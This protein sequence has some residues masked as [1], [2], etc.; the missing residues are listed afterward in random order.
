MYSEKSNKT[1]IPARIG[2]KNKSR[3]VEAGFC[4]HGSFFQPKLTVG[5][6]NDPAERQADQLADRVMRQ[7]EEEQEETLQAKISPL[8]VQRFCPEC[9]EEEEETLQLKDHGREPTS[10]EA[11]PIVNRALGSSGMP[12]DPGTRA[13]M[14]NRM[15]YDFSNVKIH[16]GSLASRSAQ[17]IQ[18]LA[19]TSGNNIVFNDGQY[20]PGTPAGN[21]LLAHELTHVVQQGHDSIRAIQRRIELR[22]PGRGEATAFDRAQELVDKIN[23]QSLGVMYFLEADGRN[24]AYR[25]LIPDAVS[26]FDFQMMDFINQDQVLPLRL[27]TSQGTVGGFPIVGDS[28]LH[29]YVDLEDLLASDDLAFQSI[30][31]HFLQERAV[32]PRYEQR[33]GTPGLDPNTPAGAVSFRRAHRAGHDAQADHWQDVMGDS[34]IRF[35]TEFRNANGDAHIVFRSRDHNYRI[36]ITLRRA[37][38]STTGGAPRRTT[39]GITRIRHN[40]QWFSVEDFL[41]LGIVPGA[42]N[43][44]R[45]RPLASGFNR[46]LNLGLGLPELQL[47]PEIQRQIRELRSLRDAVNPAGPLQLPLPS[48]SP[49]LPSPSATQGT[50]NPL[51]N[52]SLV[53]SLRP[54][55]SQIDWL[56]IQNELHTRGVTMDDQLADSITSVWQ[57]NYRFFNQT[58]GMSSD[59]AT[60]WTNKTIGRAVG[61]GL[62]YDFPTMLEQSDRELGTSS[63]IFP[64]SDVLM[65][66]WDRL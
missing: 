45:L 36:F 2:N 63:T 18:A 48:P 53:P 66:L 58:L 51:L 6:A 29:G 27:I 15:G 28:Y 3:E 32:T 57:T 22:P 40:N 61:S 43:R 59:Q 20:A 7:E 41:D 62:S 9:E 12:L 11:P 26:G 55:N 33:I 25:I 34:S 31:V 17:S 14:E 8:S 19:Y 65:F 56:P 46:D 47:D 60:F 37:L 50:P 42:R 23:G 49:G 13:N 1:G 35:S 24:L 64:V 21:K 10:R 39:G 38:P 30:L 54:G 16:T 4:S 52:P 44:F 5:P